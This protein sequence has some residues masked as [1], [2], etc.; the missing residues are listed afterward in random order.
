MDPHSGDGFC[1][2]QLK[3]LSR[4]KARRHDVLIGIK[5]N[6]DV[7]H[8]RLGHPNHQV[9]QFMLNHQQI[10]VLKS[11]SS[12]LLCTPCQLAK[13]RKLPFCDNSHVTSTPLEL[14]H[15]DIWISPVLS[16]NGNKY[17]ICFVDDI[18]RYTWL[19]PLKHKSDVLEQF[20]KFKCLT[21]NLFS[22][23]IKQ[24]QTDGGGEYSSSAFSKFLANYG[25]FHRSTCPIPHNRIELLRGNID[26]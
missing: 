2:M 22:L 25:I 5:T 8:S 24:L 12:Q 20:V 21:E 18:S 3:K 7:W 23:R 13:S 9:L 14:I 10:P 16:T 11:K 19:I 4:N 1:S 26:I 17:Y 6:V 15:S